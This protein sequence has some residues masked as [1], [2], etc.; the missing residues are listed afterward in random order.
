MI[1]ASPKGRISLEVLEYGLTVHKLLLCLDDGSTID[2]IPG[3]ENGEVHKEKRSFLHTIIGRYTNRLPTGVHTI[4]DG[5]TL[6]PE[7]VESDKVSHHGGVDA[8]DTKTFNQITLSQSQL[9]DDRDTLPTHTLA[10]FSYVSKPLENGYPGEM[11]IEAGFFVADDSV[12]L[13]HRAKMLDGVACPVNLTQHWGFNLTADQIKSSTIADHSLR[14][15]ATAIAETDQNNLATGG[16][17]PIEGSAFDFKTPRKIGEKEIVQDHYYFFDRDST[18]VDNTI[19]QDIDAHVTDIASRRASEDAQLS[20]SSDS[21]QLNFLTNQSGV[22]F[23]AGGG[24]SDSAPQRKAGHV[25]AKDEKAPYPKHGCAFF[26]FHHPLS[27]FLHEP[28]AKHANTSTILNKEEGN[29][30]QN[31]VRMDVTLR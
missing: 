26:E 31:W 16:K 6:T 13:T 29:V 30:Y 8:F 18:A 17:V 14:L 22:M 28:Y 3:P 5:V 27:T 12:V 4:D 25:D 20:L 1:V 11:L 10:L 7:P 21:V 23:Y 24:F 19:T 2:I 9:Y 15:N